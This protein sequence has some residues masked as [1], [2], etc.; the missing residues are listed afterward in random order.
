MLL[1]TSHVLRP[2]TG[3]CFFVVQ[4]PSDTELLGGGPVPTGPVAGAGGLVTEDAV[5]PVA[6]LCALRRVW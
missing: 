6:V 1:T 4:Q 2:V 5:Q 3:V